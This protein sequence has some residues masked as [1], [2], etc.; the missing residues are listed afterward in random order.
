MKREPRTLHKAA[1]FA[2]DGIL[3]PCDDVWPGEIRGAW[4]DVTCPECL[5]LGRELGYWKG[6]NK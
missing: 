4:D 2:P 3:C 1:G 6:A 5:A